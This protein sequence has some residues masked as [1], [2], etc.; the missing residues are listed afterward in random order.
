[1]A[2][3]TY[4]D[5]LGVIFHRLSGTAVDLL[6]ELRELA[7]NVGGVAVENWGVTSTNLTRVVEDNDLSVER[8]GTHGRVVLGVTTDVSTNA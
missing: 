1:V 3:V 6:E 4:L 8:T 5:E 2:A 7:G